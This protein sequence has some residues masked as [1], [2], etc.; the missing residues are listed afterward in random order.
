MIKVII[1]T[2]APCSYCT[3]CLQVFLHL[4]SR[5]PLLPP[6]SLTRYCLTLS[7]S[8]SLVPSPI[9]CSTPS[10]AHLSFHNYLSY[11]DVDHLWS[12]AHTVAKQIFIKQIRPK[13]HLYL[14]LLNSISR[15]STFKNVLNFP[16]SLIFSLYHPCSP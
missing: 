5:T 6:R 7:Y 9:L 13:R 15:Q 1:K 11:I 10:M 14:Q 3:A 8:V 4:L 2:L 16:T 12:T